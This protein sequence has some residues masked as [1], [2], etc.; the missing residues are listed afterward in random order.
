MSRPEAQRKAQ[1]AGARTAGGVSRKV[2]LVVAGPGSGSKRSE[3]EKL[4]IRVIDE[5]E[6]LK[7]IGSR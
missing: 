1:E 3:A 4:G 6:F 2:T 7:R 5:G